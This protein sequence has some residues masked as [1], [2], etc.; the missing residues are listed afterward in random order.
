MVLLVACGPKPSAPAHPEGHRSSGS[1]HAAEA[2]IK[3]E[4]DQA[5]PVEPDRCDRLIGHVVMLAVAERPAEQKP[6]ETERGQ[7]ITQL[8]TAWVPRCEAMTATGY[9]CVLAAQTLGQLETCAA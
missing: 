6:T 1:G 8:R 7:I 3:P 4:A 9:D 5:K 2:E